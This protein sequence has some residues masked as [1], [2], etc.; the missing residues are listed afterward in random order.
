MDVFIF[1]MPYN[2]VTNHRSVSRK[3]LMN[4]KKENKKYLEKEVK[5]MKRTALKA[6][7]AILAFVLVFSLSVG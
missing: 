7:W 1:A 2:R 5:I 6:L 4:N 3:R